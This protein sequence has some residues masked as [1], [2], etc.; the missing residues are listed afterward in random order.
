MQK[1]VKHRAKKVQKVLNC[2]DA[3]ALAVFALSV[4]TLNIELLN[5]LEP[6]LIRQKASQRTCPR[7]SGSMRLE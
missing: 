1:A 2:T 5:E 6:R 4:R 7:E 3:I